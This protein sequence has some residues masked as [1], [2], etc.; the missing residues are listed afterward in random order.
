M[1]RAQAF[2][3]MGP[4]RHHSEHHRLTVEDAPCTPSM[5]MHMA[6]VLQSMQQGAGSGGTCEEQLLQL[7]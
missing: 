1:R 4:C 6:H 2:M 5:C 7:C 3:E